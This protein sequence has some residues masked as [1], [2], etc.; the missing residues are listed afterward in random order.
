MQSLPSLAPDLPRAAESAPPPAPP[1][2]TPAL[3][4]PALTAAWHE[5]AP[6]AVLDGERDAVVILVPLGQTAFHLSIGHVGDRRDMVVADPDLCVLAPGVAHGIEARQRAA[7][8]VLCLDRARW[9]ERAGAVLGRAARVRECR[10]GPDAFLRH[11][12]RQLAAGARTG[13]QPD[14]AWLDA[15]AMDLA[16]HLATRYA[17][18]VPAANRAGLA[19]ERLERVLALIEGRLAEAIQV[20]DLAASVR[21]SPYHFA[22]LFKQSMGQAPHLYITWQRMDRAKELLA[23]S[24]LPLAQVATRVGYHTQAHFTGVFHA[25]VGTTPRAYRLGSRL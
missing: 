25:R 16:V 15:M 10:P 1:E 8:A 18:P 2:L 24:D 17:R 6:G 5:I 23:Q 12:A 9:E 22:R 21:M 4:V 11:R 7:L 14:P 19:P 3:A 20:R 13:V